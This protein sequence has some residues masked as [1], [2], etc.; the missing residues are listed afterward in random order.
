MGCNRKE[1]QNVLCK[2]ALTYPQTVK[3]VCLDSEFAGINTKVDDSLKDNSRKTHK[4]ISGL[5]VNII[6]VSTS[7]I[8]NIFVVNY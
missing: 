5:R 6:F 3:T 1:S 7:S 8:R 2:N 4:H